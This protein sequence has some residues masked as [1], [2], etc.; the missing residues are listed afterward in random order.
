MR[1]AISLRHALPTRPIVLRR[2]SNLAARALPDGT[3]Y[4]IGKNYAAH[5]KELPSLLGL[6]DE[7]P[8]T[9]LIFIK[10]P[11]TIERHGVKLMIPAW[12]SDVQHEAR[13][14]QLLPPSH[15]VNWGPAGHQPSIG[16][17]LPSMRSAG[18]ACC[19]A[20]RRLATLHGGC[21]NRLDGSRCAGA[22]PIG[23]L[24]ADVAHE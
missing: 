3:V 6:P 15:G 23:I 7:A 8:T 2:A 17:V 10:S 13:V 24:G 5:I 4:C 1:A 20:G 19:A 21:G 9:P 18:G 22:H 16:F 11:A 12:S 14:L